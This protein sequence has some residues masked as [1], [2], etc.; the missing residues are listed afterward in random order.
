MIR[1]L[2]STKAPEET[3]R[4]L[5]EYGKALEYIQEEK[6]PQAE[7][8]LAK[9]LQ[10]L[11]AGGLYGQPAYNFL[12]LRQALIQRAQKKHEQ[13]E[14]TLEE[15]TT[16]YKALESSHSFQLE[17][18]YRQLMSQYLHS[19][20]EKALKLGTL[21]KKET[22]SLQGNSAFHKDV[23]FFLGVTSKQTAHLLKGQDFHAAQQH[24]NTCLELNPGP[25]YCFVLHNLAC[26]Q[27]WH[28]RHSPSETTALSFTSA[29]PNFQ[30][31]INLFEG[32][33]GLYSPT[34]ESAVLCNKLSG[35]SLT[36]IAELQFQSSEVSTALCYLKASLHFYESIDRNS[37]GRALSLAGIYLKSQEQYRD[38]E[39]VLKDAVQLLKNVK[40]K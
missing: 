21:L 37:M 22:E 23:L 6:Y 11:S 16:N 18:A 36:S 20:I 25:N 13:T 39:R 4:G 27:W 14:K 35:L 34:G 19:N 40:A 8:E 33:A 3:A 9:C 12:L 30:R 26:S 38:A 29:V 15:I 7:G 5:L 10:T 32:H 24:F 28:I 2:L 31:A 1:R 17:V